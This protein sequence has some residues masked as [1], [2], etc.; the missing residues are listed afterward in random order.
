MLEL[1]IGKIV[2][3]S[4][5]GCDKKSLSNDKV[6]FA[7]L[8]C[9]FVLSD[10]RLG[11][12]KQYWMLKGLRQIGRQIFVH[13][14]L[15]YFF[16]YQFW[17]WYPLVVVFYDWIMRAIDLSHGFCFLSREFRNQII[18]MRWMVSVI[19]HKNSCHILSL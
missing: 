6:N 8:S 2:K 7:N 14:L 17:Y 16:H 5:K 11:S 10:E 18:T 4:I 13:N 19:E 15:N 1:Q 3:R 9:K 12:C